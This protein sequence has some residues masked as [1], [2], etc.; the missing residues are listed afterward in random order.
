MKTI[1]FFVLVPFILFAQEFTENTIKIQATSTLYVPADQI[2]IMVQLFCDNKQPAAA[3]NDFYELKNKFLNIVSQYQL[4]DSL[5]NYSVLAFSRNNTVNGVAFRADQNISILLNRTS[6]Y[7]KFQIDFFENGFTYFHIRYTSSELHSY[8]QEGYNKAFSL[9]KED[10]DY[11][12][13]SMGKT[14][15]NVISVS[16][17][18]I[19]YPEIDNS[20]TKG[21]VYK[22]GTA[23]LITPPRVKLETVIEVLFSTSK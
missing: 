23:E 11:I 19:D 22:F 14:L 7:V 1:L 10:A 8:K 3:L 21:E 4:A 20:Y 9:A 5:I 18:V 6:D 16:T 17:K 12:A 2:L 15:G 13:K